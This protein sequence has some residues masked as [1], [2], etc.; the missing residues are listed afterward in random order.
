LNSNIFSKVPKRYTVK[1]IYNFD[2]GTYSYIIDQQMSLMATYIAYNEIA[3][4]GFKDARTKI[5]I[6]KD[7]A[8]RELNNIKKIYG[9]QTDAYFDS[10]NRLTANAYLLLDQVTKIMNKYPEIKIEVAMH[11]DNTG[12]PQD[13]LN[14]S[15][16]YARA[17]INYL[18]I[19]GIDS[20][21]LVAKGFGGS[22]PIAPNILGEDRITNRRVDFS[23]IRE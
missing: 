22:R 4:I 20:N 21:R 2:T 3:G 8:A 11:T 12:L 18:I 7:P 23:V 5:M 1:E 10:Y 17:F 19:K 13:K 14:L 15:E 9:I 6:L 16:R